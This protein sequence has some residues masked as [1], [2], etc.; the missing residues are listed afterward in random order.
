M[1]HV[2]KNFGESSKAKNYGTVSLLSCVTKVFEKPV[3]NR[4]VDTL[5]KSGLFSDLH[6][7]LTSSRSTAYLL[8]VV[9]DRTAK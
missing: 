2:I 5:E 7:G 6:Y 4:L 8:T 3:N 1:V 9:S